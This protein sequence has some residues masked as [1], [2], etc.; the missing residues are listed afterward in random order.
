MARAGIRIAGAW[1]RT[2]T[3]L[4]VSCIGRAGRILDPGI[5]A[6]GNPRQH[7]RLEDR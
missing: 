3:P 7:I 2:V 6:G 4:P 5:L 1:K